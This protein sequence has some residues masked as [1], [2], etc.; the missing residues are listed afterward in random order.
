MP[1]VVVGGKH[2]GKYRENKLL[3]KGL[4][5]EK[6]QCAVEEEDGRKISAKH[7]ENKLLL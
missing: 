5:R 4:V 6:K 1:E 3:A 7:L 2:D